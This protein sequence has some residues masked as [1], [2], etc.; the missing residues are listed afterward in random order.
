MLSKYSSS[1]AN[2]YGIKVR[3]VNKLIPNLGNKK[4]YVIHYRN[5]QLYISLEMKVTKVHNI[6]K[7]KQSD[8]LKK[9]VDFN[10]E[11]RKN[12]I[13]NFEK[14]FFKL[15]IN[16]VFG[17][18]IENLRKRI[19]VRLINNTKDY[20]NCVSQP[21][22]VSQKIFSK[23]F[24]AIHKIKS[25][26]VLNKPIYVGFSILE[27]SKLLIYNFHYQYFKN[28]FNARLLFTDTDSLVYEIRG[29]NDMYEKIYSD[30]DLLDFSDY[31]KNSK[32]YDV[33]NKKVIGKMKDELSGKVISEFIGLK[34]KMYSLISVDDE[35]KIRAK[36]VSKKLK[37]SEFVDVLFN[38]KVIRHNMKRIQSRIHR[39]GTYDVFKIS[40]SCLVDKRYALDD[41]V[42]TVAYFH[43]DIG[44]IMI[45]N[46]Y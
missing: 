46:D 28:K 16:I 45:V 34:P 1:I 15:M 43:K 32:F 22:I 11:K 23:N 31:L 33:T 27:L 24:F 2:N 30:R 40:L 18:T 20:V 7:F 17:K 10:T 36:G 6:L 9:F 44:S 8:W 35:E 26:L 3:E 21:T 25:V 14:N 19:N 12:A 5:L 37:H 4:N 13:N 38:E 42:N 29:K 41:G 39:L